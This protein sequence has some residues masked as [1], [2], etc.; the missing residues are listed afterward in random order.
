MRKLYRAI[1]KVD[2]HEVMRKGS[3][4]APQGPAVEMIVAT[5]SATF[6]AENESKNTAMKEAATRAEEYMMA[7]SFQEAE[8]KH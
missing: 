5:E 4:L 1:V 7:I 8:S 3:E 2:V 6:Y